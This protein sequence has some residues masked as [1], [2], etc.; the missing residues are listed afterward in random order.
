MVWKSR[1][2]P[3][4]LGGGSP[5][6]APNSSS[7]SSS[8]SSIVD[9]SNTTKSHGV[10]SSVPIEEEK[11]DEPSVPKPLDDGFLFETLPKIQKKEMCW[12]Q[13]KE[14]LEE[15]FVPKKVFLFWPIL[16]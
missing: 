6:Y 5:S 3:P 1:E 7:C 16:L 9:L 13:L 10:P 12:W 15:L 11:E 14:I 8:S 4:T 2:H